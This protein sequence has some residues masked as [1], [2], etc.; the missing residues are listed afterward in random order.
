MAGKLLGLVAI[1]ILLST[2]LIMALSSDQLAEAKTSK[3]SPK[4]KYSKW[5]KKVCGDDL[6]PDNDF[7]RTKQ[8]IGKSRTPR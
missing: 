1:S 2:V 8:Y 7:M 5:T 3:Q 4:H 6:C